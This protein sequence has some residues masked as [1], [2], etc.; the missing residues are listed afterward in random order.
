MT[1]IISI[2]ITF[3][4]GLILFVISYIFSIFTFNYNIYTM[5]I[6]ETF[7]GYLTDST[8]EIEILE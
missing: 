8:E 2:I 3:P 6:F 1:F 7:S 5:N 4:I